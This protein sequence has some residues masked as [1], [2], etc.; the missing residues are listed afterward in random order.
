MDRIALDLGFIKIY[1]YSVFILLGIIVAFLIAYKEAKRIN[2]DVRLLSD[3]VFNIIIVGLIG[4]RLYYVLFNLSYYISNP[5]ETIAIWKGGLAIHGGLIAALIYIVIYCKKKKVDILKLLD[6]LVV[7]LIIAQA[8]G[9][10]G[11]FFNQEAYGNITTLQA[12]KNQKIPMFVIDGMYIL[13]SYRQPTFFYESILCTIGFIIMIITRRYKKLKKGE[14]TGFYLIWYGIVRFIIEQ[15]RT[16]SLM[17]G[18]IK[19]AQLISGLFILSGII[20][21]IYNVIKNKNENKSFY[22]KLN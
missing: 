19:M 16:D 2:F 4:A 13:G 17:L 5:L 12:L 11:N 8:I 10:W 20:L 22:N 18:S 9:R 14:L 1:W 3:L 6:I 21:F 7:S 15:L